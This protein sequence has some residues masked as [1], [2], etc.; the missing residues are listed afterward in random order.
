MRNLR[1]VLAYDGTSFSGWQRQR[2]T[3]D[4]IQ[5]LLEEALQVLTGAPVTL[6]G[7]GR[8]D[9]GVHAEGMVANFHTAAEIPAAGLL[10][11]ANSLLP[12]DIRVLSVENVAKDFHA[13]YNARGKEYE[14]SFVVA[15]VMPPML[16]RYAAHVRRP[17]DMEAIRCTLPALVGRH[18]FR[19]FEATGSRDVATDGGEGAVRTVFAARLE[20]EA[21]SLP[22]YRFVISGNGFLRYMVRNIVGTLFEVGKGKLS[23]RGF[24]ELIAA[25]DRT[26][27][28]P[29]APAHG[30]KLKRVFY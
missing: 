17:L 4:T 13:R 16:R 10:Q 6:H 25:Q 1:L 30:L 20:Q 7:A 8:T 12:A 26:L 27:A 18:D 29:T 23:P 19:S 15:A 2:N 5:G 22:L 28:G 9:G 3:P 21:G 14:Y 11:G 24:A